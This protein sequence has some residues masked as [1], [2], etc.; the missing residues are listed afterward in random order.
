LAPTADTIAWISRRFTDEHRA[1]L[2]WLNEITDGRF[3]FFGL[4]I[5]VWKIG[6]SGAAPKFNIVSKPN[7]WYRDVTKGTSQLNRTELTEIKK[8]QLDCWSAFKAHIDEHGASFK[9]MKARPQPW[10]NFGIGKSGF[11]I[12]AIASL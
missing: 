5:E 7:D 6:N 4:E 8:L 12:T 2:D 11:Y 3:R 9:S 1:A 10:Q